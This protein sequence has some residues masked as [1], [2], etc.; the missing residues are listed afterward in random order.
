M[1]TESDSSFSGRVSLNMLSN[2]ARI[3]VMA[4][5]GLLM[6]PY[7]IDKFGMA[8]YAILPLATSLTTYIQIA[9]ESLASSF[10]R[11][12]IMA[13]QSGDEKRSVKTYTSM[14]IGMIKVILKVIPI[15][16][17][18]SI[19]SPFIFQIGPANAT[20]VQVMFSLILTSAVM[21]A[22]TSCLDSVFYS[23]NLLY[24]LYYIKTAYQL[25]QVGLIISLFFVFG[26]NLMLIG[27]A[28]FVSSVIFI[29]WEWIAVKFI[30]PHLKISKG[31]FDPV[32]LKEMSHLGFWAIISAIGSMMFIQTSLILVNL[33]M[34]TETESEFSIVAN[35]ISM[36][37][38]ACMAMTAAGEP[39]VYRYYS[40]GNREMMWKTLGL[41]TKFVG[42]IIV[43]PIAFI[44]IFTPQILV[45]WIGSDYNFIVLMA[46][47][48][49]PAN[50]AVCA[51][52]ILNCVFLIESRI[53]EV[54]ITTCIL[55]AFNILLACIL[56]AV[57]DDPVG[58]SIAWSVSI[59]L[60]NGLFF[61]L[62]AA[63]I[64]DSERMKFIRPMLLCFFV[65][66]ILIG[67]GALL[68]NYWTM[69]NRLLPLVVIALVSFIIYSV[70]AFF[71]LLNRQEQGT[72]LTYFP[73]SFQRFV[74]K[75]I[76]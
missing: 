46:R 53:R 66:L 74:M 35:M 41:F 4:L 72:V 12:M 56:L 47:I 1:E 75:F 22:L 58:A 13:I 70:I 17:L 69:P 55:G 20:E 26:P 15:A 23:K 60:L 62:F 51:T 10:S 19:L 34:G 42:L 68:C 38:T 33:F 24:H 5:L 61:P 9:S 6:V 59:L 63:K 43:F 65:F 54:A 52:R 31:D 76:H 28:Y 67:L 3:V 14:M 18:I 11:Y 73:Q 8:T 37:N 30:C 2:I 45:V 64:L 40:E 50:I 21:L 25:I 48:M 39:L 16:L 57:M 49:I 27:A 32:L 29:T 44:C 7:Y 36:V 71:L